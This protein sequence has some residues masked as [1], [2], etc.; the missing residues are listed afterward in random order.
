MN[1]LL[2]LM[3]AYGIAFLLCDAKIFMR[4]RNWLEKHSAFLCELLSCYFCSGFWASVLVY[5]LTF[6]DIV[7]YEY[8]ENVVLCSLAGATFC[9]LL[10]SILLVLEKNIF[11]Q[12]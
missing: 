1:Q 6:H 8:W 4:P 10:N 5:S 11:D 9:H 12:T 2:Q 7:G 3:A